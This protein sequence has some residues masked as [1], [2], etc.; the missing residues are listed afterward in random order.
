[1][2]KR[3]YYEVLGVHA[4]VT[5]T[6]LKS[7]YRKLAMQYHPDRNPGNPDAEHR[8]KEVSEAYDVLKDPQRRA[9]YDR[10]GHQAFEG[11]GFGGGGQAGFG[12]DFASAMSDI[13]DEFFGMGP[14][15]RSG[16][17]R[18]G[19][20]GLPLPQLLF[21]GRRPADIGDEQNTEDRA[22]DCQPNHDEGIQKKLLHQ[23]S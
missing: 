12:G 5:E 16:G 11:G 17:G 8:F 14:R 2:A 15:K 23:V 10:F 19:E 1:M 6:E 13:F 20:I 18:E 9:A 3:D 7:A 21:K 4:Q 22:G